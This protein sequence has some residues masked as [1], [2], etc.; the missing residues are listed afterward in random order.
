MNEILDK[1]KELKNAADHSGWMLLISILCSIT[2]SY[3]E[4]V[5][6]E[7]HKTNTLLKTMVEQQ[8]KKDSSSIANNNHILMPKNK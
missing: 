6:D 3:V 1:I 7:L 4:N 8:M 5:K 2:C